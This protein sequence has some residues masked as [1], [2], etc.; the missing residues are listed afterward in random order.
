MSNGL[1]PESSVNDVF[2]FIDAGDGLRVIPLTVKQQ[3]DDTR[4]AIF[5]KGE[6]GIASMMMAELML[7][8]EEMHDLAEQGQATKDAAPTIITA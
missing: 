7:R 2:D 4:L 3:E 8:I 5:I 6:H 1:S